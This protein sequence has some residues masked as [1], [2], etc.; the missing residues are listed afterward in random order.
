MNSKLTAAFG[1]IILAIAT[2]I[3]FVFNDSAHRW[4]Y[5]HFTTARVIIKLGDGTNH[6]PATKILQLV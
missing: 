5:R 3:V 6:F 2:F 1:V 4:Y